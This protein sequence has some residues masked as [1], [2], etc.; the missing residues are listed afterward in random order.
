[1]TVTIKATT[2]EELQHAARCIE[3]PHRL[4][5]ALQAA[6]IAGPY[7]RDEDL[8]GMIESIKMTGDELIR[9]QD[10]LDRTRQHVK[11]RQRYIGELERTLQVHRLANAG[12]ESKLK[13]TLHIITTMYREAEYNVPHIEWEAQ[14]LILTGTNWLS[15]QA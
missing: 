1:M 5:I 7:M 4:N 3:Y 9:L 12:W 11:D 10:K 14:W 8:E 6:R 13:N 2:N 15:D